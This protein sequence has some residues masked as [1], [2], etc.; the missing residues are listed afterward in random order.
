MIRRPP[1]STLFPYT[2]LFR[3]RHRISKCVSGFGIA[4]RARLELHAIHV[5]VAAER[6]LAGERRGGDAGNAAHRLQGLREEPVRGA[7]LIK[8][9]TGRL[10]L[11][12][13]Q[14]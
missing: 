7:V 11:H 2:T 6:Q 12:G 1:R 5:K 8:S 9:M 3:S 14:V 10:D 13:E 4:V